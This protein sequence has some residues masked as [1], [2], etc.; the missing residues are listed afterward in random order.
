VGGA[1]GVLDA[2]AAVS[3]TP[4]N[5]SNRSPPTRCCRSATRPYRATNISAAK[6]SASGPAIST[7]SF[8]GLREPLARRQLPHAPFCFSFSTTFDPIRLV[9]PITTIS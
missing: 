6:M 8:I 9:P 7:V 1:A 4:N 3:T 2:L 5:G